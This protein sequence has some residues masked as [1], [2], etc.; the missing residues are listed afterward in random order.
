MRRV[1]RLFFLVGFGAEK[2]V[3]KTFGYIP[4]NSTSLFCINEDKFARLAVVYSRWVNIFFFS[5]DNLN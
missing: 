3:K 5:L 2:K 1:F 4:F